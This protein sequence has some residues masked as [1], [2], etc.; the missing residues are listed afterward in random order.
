MQMLRVCTV[1]ASDPKKILSPVDQLLWPCHLPCPRAKKFG[2]KCRD[3]NHFWGCE[4]C[5]QTLRFVK[6]DGKGQKAPITHLFCDCGG[7]RVDYLTFRCAFFA[8]HG[9]QFHAFTSVNLLNK[10]LERQSKKETLTLFLEGETGNGKSTLINEMLFCAK[11]PTFE[12]AFRLTTPA[13]FNS[14][15]LA[16]A[17]YQG[18]HS[19]AQKIFGNR[20]SEFRGSKIF[21]KSDFRGRKIFRKSE[22]R[23][24]KRRKSE[25]RPQKCRKSEFRAIPASYSKSV[26]QNGEYVTIEAKLGTG[27]N[28]DESQTQF[29]EAYLIPPVEDGQPCCVSDTEGKNDP[30]GIGMDNQNKANMFGFFR[31][32]DGVHAIGV[33]MKD[34]DNRDTKSFNYCIN[35]GILSDLHKSGAPNIVFLITHSSGSAKVIP[36]VRK[37][38]EEIEKKNGVKIPLN[39]SNV[40]C[41]DNVAFE[42]LC[43]IKTKG[44]EYDEDEMEEFSRKRT[45]SAREF[46]RLKQYLATLKPHLTRETL[47]VYDARC[48]IADIIPVIASHGAQIQCNIVK[49]EIEKL[50]KTIG[51]DEKKM[52]IKFDKVVT[53]ELDKP[54]MV[55]TSDKCSEVVKTLGGD[56]KVSKKDCADDYSFAEGVIDGTIVAA[57]TAAG[58]LGPGTLLGCLIVSKRRDEAKCK[59]CK[60]PRREHKVINTEQIVKRNVDVDPAVLEQIRQKYKTLKMKDAVKRELIE[61]RDFCCKEAAKWI[62]CLK[63][64]AVKT[65]DDEMQSCIKQNIRDAEE[66]MAKLKGQSREEQNERVKALRKFEE[67]Y[68]KERDILFQTASGNAAGFKFPT[69]NI[70]QIFGEI[71]AK[72]M[73]G[74]DMKTSYE[75]VKK[76]KREHKRQFTVE[77][78]RRAAKQNLVK[79]EPTKCQIAEFGASS[80]AADV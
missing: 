33:V 64:M 23:A 9:D 58:G 52:E 50:N 79:A 14:D 46:K 59:D 13:D 57:C 31:G 27:R 19:E 7:T 72:K 75:V 76:A 53:K 8:D 60:C 69:E 20:K 74:K 43:L 62:A 28:I 54:R 25:F 36:V 78:E 47:S 34:N 40:F 37:L 38:L 42:A 30:R 2:G 71:F 45:K 21:R 16:A 3:D 26:E 48:A 12:D 51:E 77:E 65:D 10:E 39:K 56:V 61:E 49:M 5:G 4:R 6:Q 55:C 44:V 29:S 35:D 70:E 22:F 11:F 80:S 67:F 18:W 63:S 24:Q 32:F 17:S 73:T 66:K 41:F 15:C 68:N 1:R